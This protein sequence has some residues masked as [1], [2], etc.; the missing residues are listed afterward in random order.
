MKENA[1]RQRGTQR[2]LSLVE[3]LTAMAVL[4][5]AAGLSM[6][7]WG[8]LVGKLR[9]QSVTQELAADV[10]LAR[11]TAVALNRAVRLDVQQQAAGACVVAYTGAPGACQCNAQGIAVCEAPARVVKSHWLPAGG[12]VTVTANVASMRFDPTIGTVSPT[13][14]LRANLPDGRA[15]A[16]VVNIMGRTRSCSPGASVPGVVA[17]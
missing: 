3:T 14:T 9:L 5:V 17:C 2:G 16:Q 15:L 11:S 6:G 10:Q 1:N 4:S 13:A 7:S 8:Q 12:P